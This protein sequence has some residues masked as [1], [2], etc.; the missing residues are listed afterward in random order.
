MNSSLVHKVIQLAEKTFVWFLPRDFQKTVIFY[1]WG[2]REN[3]PT[4]LILGLERNIPFIM[5]C[6]LEWNLFHQCGLSVNILKKGRTQTRLQ[7]RG[8]QIIITLLNKPNVVKYP[9][10]WEGSKIPK[11]YSRGFCTAQKCPKLQKCM[12]NIIWKSLEKIY[13]NVFTMFFK[14]KI[15]SPQMLQ[16]CFIF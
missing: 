13:V 6:I 1:I 9:Q 7:L 10:K 4:E 8:S 11:T 15:N 2:L 16:I 3:K 14:S 5:E 12:E